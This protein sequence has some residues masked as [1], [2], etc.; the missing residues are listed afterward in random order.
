MPDYAIA[1]SLQEA[2]EVSERIGYPMIIKPVDNGGSK[3]VQRV[4]CEEELLDYFEESM[5]LSVTQSIV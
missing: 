4:N 3:G 1:H 5:K 2:L